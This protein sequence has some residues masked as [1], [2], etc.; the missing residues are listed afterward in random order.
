MSDNDPWELPPKEKKEKP[1]TYPFLSFFSSKPS[2][3]GT[4]SSLPR[5]LSLEEEL[6][7]AYVSGGKPPVHLTKVMMMSMNIASLRASRITNETGFCMSV[8][9]F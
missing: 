2:H 6:S 7:R 9:D 1:F 8:R 3:T 4:W 5:I